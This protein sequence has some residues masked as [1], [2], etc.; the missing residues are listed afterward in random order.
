MDHL[1]LLCDIGELNWIFSDSASSQSFLQRIVTI[2]AEHM[3]AEVCSIYVYDDANAELT[4]KAT[5]GL[6]RESVEKVRLKLGEGLVGLALQDRR[7]ICEPIASAN[8]HFKFFP[9]ILE[10]HFESFLVVPILRGAARIG[11]LTVQRRQEQPFGAQDV[12]ALRAVALQLAN[13]LEN[14]QLL[15]TLQGPP[16]RGG[17]PATVPERKFI[18]GKVASE[19]F[20]C[21][22]AVVVDKE[23]FLGQVLQLDVGRVYT[24][25]D[26]QRSV[27]VTEGQ[28]R[29]SQRL[30]EERFAEDV[31]LIFASHLLMLRDAAFLGGMTALIEA[32]D[33]APAAVLKTAKHY[34]DMFAQHDNAYVREKAHDLK[35]LTLRLLRNLLPEP[36]TLSVWRDRI[37]V[38]RDLFPSDLL[39]M[40]SEGVSGLIVT[41][42][43][44]T[45]HI[46]TLAR[47]LR[48]PLVIVDAPVLLTLPEKTTILLDGDRGHV[49][50]DPAPTVMAN[51][52]AHR[53]ARRTLETD[54]GSVR[55]VSLTRDG[56]RIR[57]LANI[58]L[59]ADVPIA[60]DL[61]AEGIGLYRTELPFLIRSTF[62][63]EDE[64]V[65]VYRKLV[66]GLPGKP[67]TFRTLDIGGDKSLAYLERPP[68]R[69][70][71]LGFRSIRFCLENP[72]VFAQQLRAI[73]RASAGAET[74]IMFPMIGS[75][76]EFLEARQAVRVC[77][78][79][80]AAESLPHNANPKIGMMVEV[81]AVVDLID[82]FAKEAEFFA[83]GTNDLIQYTLAAD[84]TNERVARS[85]VPHHPSV[86]R[87]IKR[88][89]DGA[90]AHNRAV[91]VCGE[92]AHEIRYLPFFL[93]IGVRTL[94]VDPVYLPRVQRAIAGMTI[95][96]AETLARAVLAQTT[97]SAI[98]EMLEAQAERLPGAR[99]TEPS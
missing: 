42:G 30:L 35:D 17:G 85:Y 94:S 70:P 2:V 20:A 79:A 41:S 44:T 10:E 72:E 47:S 21:A 4:L 18:K 49:F 97:A 28:V 93:G 14:A 34:L 13:I 1:R 98:G 83:I 76:E 78:A 81:P 73:L 66:E 82:A 80:L 99:E 16:Q 65:A 11:V 43:G 54:Q 29:N 77:L 36:E 57:L 52:A 6:S 9:G 26:F 69:N 39:Q 12:L 5:K 71:S 15:M 25:E 31:S 27:A 90:Y 61:A 22:E 58:N 38:T 3:Q 23:R 75:L 62:P 63:T 46:A 50:V 59:L 48:L 53:R 89:V 92:M 96:E 74:Q 37:V 51:F 64:Q 40:A 45:A 56:C 67:I 7:P 91:S 32:G 8:P 87:A 33:S 95:G 84:R 88:I 19:G 24:L 55:P 86:L 68:E 60:R